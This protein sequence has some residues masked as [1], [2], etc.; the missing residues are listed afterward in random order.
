MR[1]NGESMARKRKS[2]GDLT[3]VF[4]TRRQFKPAASSL[5]TKV[6]AVQTQS[7]QHGEIAPVGTYALR[8]CCSKPKKGKGLEGRGQKTC[9]MPPKPGQAELV[10]PS[11]KDVEKYKTKAGP[12]LWLCTGTHKGTLLPVSDPRTAKKIAERYRAC[13]DG[14]RAKVKACIAE[15]SSKE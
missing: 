5:S 11:R 14:K 9:N 1:E 3:T 8:G 10:F 15:V 7:V 13:A 4:G 2:F 6:A 12:A